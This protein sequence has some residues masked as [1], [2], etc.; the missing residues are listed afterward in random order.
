MIF[1]SDHYI[2]FGPNRMGMFGKILANGSRRAKSVNLYIAE[3]DE[4]TTFRPTY[5]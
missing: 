4:T 5:Y 3:F 1:N 2:L